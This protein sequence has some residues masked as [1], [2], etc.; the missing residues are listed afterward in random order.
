MCFLVISVE[1]HP[2]ILLYILKKWLRVILL[3]P[4]HR[5]EDWLKI[6]KYVWEP[7]FQM[8][9]RVPQRDG[10]SGLRGKWAEWKAGIS[11]ECTQVQITFPLKASWTHR[12]TEATK[13]IE[14][15]HETQNSKAGSKDL[16]CFCH[17]PIGNYYSFGNVLYSIWSRE[18]S[19]SK[20]EDI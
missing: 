5:A 17:K 6:Y 12:W 14:I 18:W 2:W 1:N 20:K 7:S 19:S 9:W 4:K 13:S 8:F 3:F 10:R 11:F 15:F 16:Q